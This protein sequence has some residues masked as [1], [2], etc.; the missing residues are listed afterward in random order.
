MDL[1]TYTRIKA[2]I[3]SL[4]VQRQTALATAEQALGAIKSL[5]W[6]LKATEKATE[7]VEAIEVTTDA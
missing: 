4:I 5:E 6:V 1:E 3:D 7:P 2:E